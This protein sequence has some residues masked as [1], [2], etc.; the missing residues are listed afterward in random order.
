MAINSTTRAPSRLGTNPRINHRWTEEEKAI[1]RRD[2][3]QAHESRADLARRLGVS[4]YA[5]QGQLAYMGLAKRTDRRPWSYEE[6]ER[7]RDLVTRHRPAAVAQQMGRSINSV[8]VRAKRLGC[9]RRARD[10]WFTKGELQSLFG[11]DHK[12]VQRRIDDGRLEG[13]AHNV[14]PQQDGGGYWRISERSVVRYV[15]AYPEELTSRN[16]DFITIVALLAG[17]ATGSEQGPRG[18]HDPPA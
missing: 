14:M 16:V 2:Y 5:V 6:D 9:S 8:V 17:I 15:R 10:G 1:I 4:E 13:E 7:L 12:W 18:P 3:S 11:V